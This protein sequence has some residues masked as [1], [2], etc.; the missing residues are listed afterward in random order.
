MNK[1]ITQLMLITAII[2]TS[3]SYVVFGDQ[4][5]DKVGT[6]STTVTAKAKDAVNDST[7]AQAEDTAFSYDFRA[8][9]QTAGVTGFNANA[10]HDADRTTIPDKVT[11][12]GKTY[13]VTNIGQQAFLNDKTL[14]SMIIPSTVTSIGT[15]AFAS[16]SLQAISLPE[17]L[18]TLNYGV[19]YGTRLTTIDIPSTVASMGN[20]NFAEIK[21]LKSATI[22]G[23]PLRTIPMNTFHDSSL[24]TVHIREGVQAIGSLA[25][26][27]TKLTSLVIPTTVTQIGSY[28]FD[29][30]NLANI[31]VPDTVQ[32]LYPNAFTGVAIRTFSYNSHTTQFVN[33]ASLNDV[34]QLNNKVK[35]IDRAQ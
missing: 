24:E 7:V 13:T 9:N 11:R 1:I 18:T 17:G 21:T 28:A 2:M 22:G 29:S 14:T 12:N 27:Q 30:P 26:A 10:P 6:I 4:L 34:T 19:F 33:G 31:T 15:Q 3:T 20:A 16:S 23:A 25:F 35:I 5:R 8:G 32:R